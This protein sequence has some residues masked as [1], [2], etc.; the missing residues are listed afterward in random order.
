MAPGTREDE[1]ENDED[2]AYDPLYIENKDIYDR[3]RDEAA[4]YHVDAMDTVRSLAVAPPAFAKDPSI[5]N[6]YIKTAIMS[7]FHHIPHTAS[8]EQLMGDKA[9][10]TTLEV[11][12][13][14]HMVV[15]ISS[16]EN[17]LGLNTRPYITYYIMCD[18]CWKAHPL[19]DL[20]HVDRRCSEL[21]CT[22][23]YW[24]PSAKNPNKRVPTKLQSHAPILPSLQRAL[25]RPRKYEQFQKWRGPGD[26]PGN[27]P[28]LSPEQHFANQHYENDK[29]CNMPDGWGWCAERAGV[30]RCCKGFDVKDWDVQSI[31]NQRFVALHCGLMLM[32]NMD[33]YAP[34]STQ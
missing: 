11:P 3:V 5:R 10:F 26:A 2:I 32:I 20:P 22:G 7:I 29:L 30:R 13:A 4:E 27:V 8:H 18:V 14:E 1:G 28:P 19:S 21:N 6:A 15:N 34:S 25:L 31:P 16:V 24:T 23:A 12:G 9:L 17:R 33:W